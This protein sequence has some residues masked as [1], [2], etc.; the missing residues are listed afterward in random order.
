MFT[1]KI[2]PQGQRDRLGEY[3]TPRASKRSR[4]R[5][6]LKPQ[7]RP[8]LERGQYEKQMDHR[9]SCHSERFA[10]RL[11]SSGAF[12]Q[13][14]QIDQK[15]SEPNVQRTARREQRGRKEVISAVAGAAPSAHKPEGCLRGI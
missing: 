14:D 3:C 2:W 6:L 10:W 12:L 8:A 7:P 13:S 5:G 1:L 4:E 11:P 15:R 9:W